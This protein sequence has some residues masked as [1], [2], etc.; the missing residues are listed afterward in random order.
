M[1]KLSVAKIIGLILAV[2]QLIV[3]GIVSIQFLNM[4]FLPT[5]YW[6]LITGV[7]MLLFL[8]AFVLQF[9]NKIH[10]IGKIISVLM[11]AVLIFGL[12]YIN[13]ANQALKDI[14]QRTVVEKNQILV[15]VKN[16]SPAKTIDDLKDSSWGVQYA[17]DVELMGKAVD[18]VKEKLGT[19]LTLTA[20]DN[21][22][23]LYPALMSGEIDAMILNSSYLDLIDEL[24]A[25]EDGYYFSNEIRIIETLEFETEKVAEEESTVRE[26]FDITE[27][28]FIL[29]VS[30]IDTYGDI[31]TR[32]RS[33]VN[34]LMIANPTTRQ[35][36]LLTTP[37]DA[38]VVIPGI[39]GS[40]KDKLTHA[41]IYGVNKSIDTLNSIYDIDIDYYARVNFNSLINIVDALG[42]VE[43]YSA[44][45]F[46]SGSNLGERF[47]YSQGYNHL[48]GEQALAFSRERY[49]LA[50][51]D[52]QRGR[53]QMEVIK[54]IVNKATSPAIL[55]GFSS[56]MAEVSDQV[57]TSVPTDDIYGL[58]KMQ[59]EDPRS[60]EMFSFDI[61]ATGSREYC[62]SY[63]GK[64]LYVAN[65]HDSSIQHA[66]GLIETIMSGGTISEADV[67]Q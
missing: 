26:D 20:F 31:S 60:W 24:T 21:Y 55:T 28:S 39:S 63:S 19:S 49:S 40:Q 18:A 67:A 11:T 54:G 35:L 9:V 62:Y 33:D 6:A 23:A 13:Q 52:N 57:Q 59:L 37:R 53:N 2:V 25:E 12:F 8:I 29:Y 7:L 66:K 64:S 50:D 41:G 17:D 51:G 42:G 22:G 45:S 15:V 4:G 3:S 30:G 44:N 48:D 65:L 1:K 27:D 58:V 36:L 14:S 61:K 56:I 16:D 34:I 32:S 46:T 10:W 47:T 43:V 38:Y 5:K